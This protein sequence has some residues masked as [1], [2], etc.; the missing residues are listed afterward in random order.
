MKDD[1]TASVALIFLNVDS[2]NGLRSGRQDRDEVRCA[3][4]RTH[5]KLVEIR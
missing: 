2:F 1:D 3:E 4:R 5:Q